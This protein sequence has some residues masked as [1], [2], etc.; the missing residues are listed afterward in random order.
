MKHKRINS[1]AIRRIALVLLAALL[2]LGELAFRFW[3]NDI[4]YASYLHTSLSRFIGG[5]VCIIFMLEFSIARP[6]RPLGN[7]RL[8]GI[9]VVLPAFAVAINNFPFFSLLA[10]DCSFAGEAT[11]IALYALSCLSIGFFEE[12]AFRGCAFMLLGKRRHTTRLQLFVAIFLS[13]AV[14]GLIH[15]VNIIESSPL[16]VL[17]QIGYSALIGALCSVVLLYTHNIWLCVLLHATYNFAG[18]VVPEFFVSGTI[19]TFSEVLFTAA[20]AVLVTAYTV[21]IFF[22]LPLDSTEAL[23]G[24]N[25][26]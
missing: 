3:L 24:E 8:L 7:K 10:K 13:S 22:K 21:Y 15:L 17:L 26:A 11:A 25:K 12:M 20:L 4:Q 19:W 6:L 18:G 9:A 2:V 16:A 5:A 23:F 14:F 1:S